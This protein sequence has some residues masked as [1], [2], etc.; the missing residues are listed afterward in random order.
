MFLSQ[1]LIR[2]PTKEA[3][4][5]ILCRNLLILML[6]EMFLVTLTSNRL[7]KLMPVL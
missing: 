2:L 5:Y 1:Y 6:C 3:R 7:Q 4:G